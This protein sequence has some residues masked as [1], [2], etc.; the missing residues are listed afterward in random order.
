MGLSIN[1]SSANNSKGYINKKELSVFLFFW[2]TMILSFIYGPFRLRG[3]EGKQSRIEQIQYKISLFLTYTTL[4][5]SPLLHSPSFPLP[6][7]RVITYISISLYSSL[8]FTQVAK[9]KKQYFIRLQDFDKTKKYL[10]REYK[11]SLSTFSLLIQHVKKCHHVV[12]AQSST[13]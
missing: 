11:S 10:G 5:Y 4:L 2:E 9:K 6:S 8:S 13:L 1:G 12:T 7:K 3:K